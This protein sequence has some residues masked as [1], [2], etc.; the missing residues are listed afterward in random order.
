LFLVVEAT[1]GVLQL[2]VE[3]RPGDLKF[4]GDLLKRYL[5]ARGCHVERRPLVVASGVGE[6]RAVAEDVF[7]RVVVVEIYRC[8]IAHTFDDHSRVAWVHV[9]VFD[10]VARLSGLL[11]EPIVAGQARAALGKGDDVAPVGGTKRRAEYS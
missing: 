9:G 6:D 11:S 1:Y 4:I 2:I 8:R 3:E 10:A 5:S 7:Q